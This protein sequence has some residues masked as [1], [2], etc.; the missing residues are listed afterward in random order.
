MFDEVHLPLAF[1]LITII[2][3]NRASE[4]PDN[5][6]KLYKYIGESILS[7]MFETEG[8]ISIKCSY[9]RDYNDPY[10]LFVTLDNYDDPDV[11]AYFNELVSNIP[12]LP[13]TCFS[14]RPDIIPMWAHYGNQSKGFVI[15]LDEDIIKNHFPDVAIKNVDYKDAPEPLDSYQISYALARGKFRHTLW[16][17]QNTINAAYFSKNSC[18]SY[19]HER[20]LVVNNELADLVGTSMILHLPQDCV[21]SIISGP[22]SSNK[23]NKLC[24]SIIDRIK[25]L[26]FNMK[27]GKLSVTPFFTCQELNSYTFNDGNIEIT[28]THCLSCGEPLDPATESSECH[29]CMMT[30][31][32]KINAAR[33]NPLRV[34]HE[35]GLLQSYLNKTKNI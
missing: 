20:R 5:M 13:T 17:Q 34:L 26:H 10:E 8:K 19:E 15:E 28:T 30:D 14:T 31:N 3:Q 24:G 16:A 23:D 2:R 11:V 22:F 12:Q 33:S 7:K 25:C 27:I 6:M 18:W 1:V 35:L 29:W 4:Q 32:D 21:T 9:P